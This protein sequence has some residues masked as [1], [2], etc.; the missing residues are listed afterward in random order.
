MDLSST[1]KVEGESGNTTPAATVS[2]RGNKGKRLEKWQVEILRE[3]FN[4]GNFWPDAD[5]RQRLA[6]ELSIDAKRVRIWF[7]NVRARSGISIRSQDS[8]ELSYKKHSETKMKTLESEKMALEGLEA[9]MS[10]AATVEGTTSGGN[11]MCDEEEQEEEMTCGFVKLASTPESSGIVPSS[12]SAFVKY[13]NSSGRSSTLTSTMISGGFSG[14]GVSSGGVFNWPFYYPATVEVSASIAIPIPTT[15]ASY[16][17]SLD[18][19]NSS[20]SGSWMSGNSSDENDHTSVVGSTDSSGSPSD[21]YT[22]NFMMM[23]TYY[24][25]TRN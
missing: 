4:A 18:S 2:R 23:K 25:N 5:E 3:Y 7:Q 24:Y 12:N 8:L 22:T 11:V 17:R 9:L 14:S 15:T 16:S 21:E 1:V 13:G 10:A 19:T 6:D 20:H